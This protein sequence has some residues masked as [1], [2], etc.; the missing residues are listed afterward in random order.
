MSGPSAGPIPLTWLL[1][2]SVA[3]ESV[4]E[5]V[6]N[7]EGSLWVEA[8]GRIWRV[9]A[10]ELTS[11]ALRRA[12]LQIV[13]LLGGELTI[14]IRR[15]GGRQFTA[16]DLVR[17]GSLPE[18]VLLDVLDALERKKNVIVSGATGSGKT[19]M[20]SAFCGLVP[21]EDRVLVIE[22]TMEIRLGTPNC[23]R[24]KAR[25]VAVRD[26]VRHAL[27]HRPDRIVVGEVRGGEATDLVDARPRG[28]GG[29]LSTI[30]ASSAVGA[31]SRLAVCVLQGV[32]EGQSY[33]VVCQRAHQAVDMVVHVARAPDGSRGV[34]EAAWVRGYDAD[35]DRWRC[36]A[37][38]PAQ[39][40]Q[41]A[42]PAKSRE[43]APTS[44]LR[45]GLARFRASRTAKRLQS[46]EIADFAGIRGNSNRKQAVSWASGDS[47]GLEVPPGLTTRLRESNGTE[48]H[49]WST[50]SGRSR[51]DPSRCECVCWR[52]PALAG[53]APVPCPV[54]P[55]PAGA[56]SGSRGIRGRSRRSLFPVPRRRRSTPFRHSPGPDSGQL[57]L[58]FQVDARFLGSPGRGASVPKKILLPPVSSE[59]AVG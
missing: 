14:T 21:M 2:W 8:R 52:A 54:C 57:T 9:E 17:N 31:L 53:S 3:G 45:R 40:R 51:A 20:L 26:L 1:H 34:V 5:I 13:R 46:R 28:H 36:E 48:P 33:P 59:L 41:G 11:A 23:V 47:D 38:G 43:T 22:D 39:E 10:P 58:R 6:I 44:G 24:F 12:A 29:S 37:F 19:T 25:G 16:G 49:A 55:V 4:S 15:F 32:T 42:D 50:V 30:H 7:R 35:A 56:A 18:A 27:R